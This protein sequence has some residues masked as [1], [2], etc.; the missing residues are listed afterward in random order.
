MNIE[1]RAW[2]SE[3][4]WM[5]D[6]FYICSEGK[7]YD[8]PRLTCDTPN[9]E[10]EEFSHLTPLLWSGL[11][12][13]NRVKV[14]QGDLIGQNGEVIGVVVFENGAFRIDDGD[15]Q[16]GNFVLDQRRADRL[17]CMGNKYQNPELI[18]VNSQ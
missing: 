1:L 14:F 15:P 12:Y 13:R 11:T 6:E 17:D 2:D 4:K 7:A 16:Q 18:P 10:I 5:D 9:I 8:T 3:N